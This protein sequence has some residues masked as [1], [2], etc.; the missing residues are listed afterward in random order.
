MENNHSHGHQNRFPEI[1]DHSHG[2]LT[3]KLIWR[4]FWILLLVTLFEVGISFTGISKMALLI[5]FI[6]LT[7]VKSYYI[8]GTFMHLKFEKQTLQ[9][10][11]LLPFVLIV[12]LI[13]IAIYE[14]T[15]IGIGYGQ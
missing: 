15:A 2:S 5:T 6:V 9:W 11:L 13:F 14:G 8:V 7:I 3:S 10:S 12:Y 4:V 1:Y